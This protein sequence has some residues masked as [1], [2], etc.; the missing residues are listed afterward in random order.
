MEKYNEQF[1]LREKKK[2]IFITDV[3]SLKVIFSKHETYSV[4]RIR[5]ENVPP[6]AYNQ[7]LK[8]EGPEIRKQSC[9]AL[10]ISACSCKCLNVVNFDTPKGYYCSRMCHKT[11][12]GISLIS[13]EFL[14]L[15]F[16]SCNILFCSYSIH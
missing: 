13:N 3:K 7:Y 9:V 10:T 11:V 16:L 6:N 4:K 2:K 5:F 12:K 8:N 1:T 15:I 14:S